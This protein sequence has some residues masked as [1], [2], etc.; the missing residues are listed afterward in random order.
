MEE[1]RDKGY[2]NLVNEYTHWH[3]ARMPGFVSKKEYTNMPLPKKIIN[4][5]YRI[6]TFGELL[7]HLTSDLDEESK[8]RFISSVYQDKEL[9]ESIKESDY[10][11]LMVSNLLRKKFDEVASKKLLY[12]KK[13]DIVYRGIQIPKDE[14]KNP[15]QLL[16]NAVI[17][18][19]EKEMS[20]VL[21]EKEIEDI[22]NKEIKKKGLYNTMNIHVENPEQSMLVST[23]AKESVAEKFA[24]RNLDKEKLAII[25][26]SYTHLTLPTKA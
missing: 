19:I 16:K 1:L 2:L 10:T 11:P 20:K 5:K 14:I 25:S 13:A 9:F 24:L 12:K 17:K 26:V 15:K 3:V 22:V 7:E 23:S 8:Q 4:E 6:E 18:R 21:S